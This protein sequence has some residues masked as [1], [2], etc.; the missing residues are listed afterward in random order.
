MENKKEFYRGMLAIAI[1][2]ALQNL[3]VS[4]LNTLDTMMISNLGPEA[5]AGV[6]LANQV[7]FFF[8]MVVF[9]TA[10]GSSVMIAQYHGRDDYPSLQKVNALSNII[11]M[12]TA[13]VF[14]FC[15]LFIPH[16]IIGLMI[17]D[18]A[19]IDSG[20]Q[21]L[22]AVAWTYPLTGISFVCGVALRSTGNARSPLIGSIIGFIFNA[23][24]NYVLIFGKFGFPALGVVGAALGTIIARTAELLVILYA[25]TRYDSPLYGPIKE[26]LN[27]KKEFIQRYMKVTV[28]VIINETLWGLGQVMYSVAYAMVGTNETAAIQVVVALQNLTFVLIRGLGNACTVILGNT[29]GKGLMDR[30]YPYAIRFLKMGAYIALIIGL[31]IS[32]LPQ[33]GLLLFPSLTPEVYQLCLTLLRY[34]GVIFILKA[35][36]SILIVGVLRGGGDT[37]FSLFLEMGSVW[38]VGVP[39]AFMG[40]ALWHLPIQWVVILASTEEIT[41]LSI[42]LLRVKSKK[43]IHEI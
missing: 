35:L 26:M 8:T 23:F 15:A 4:S 25:I 24:F 3:I 14:M 13:L 40:A 34:M 27:F 1:P 36:N 30:V 21:Y 9:G 38:F 2:I 39:L 33:I 22:R 19:V 10:T 5:I 42:G 11:A 12:G 6:G 29:I 32:L 7:F 20:A 18:P 17:D 16:E 43:W 31:F 41:K 37:K 28:P